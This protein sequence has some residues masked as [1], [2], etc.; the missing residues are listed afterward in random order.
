MTMKRNLAKYLAKREEK[1]ARHERRAARKAAK[2]Q[3]SVKEKNKA[4]SRRNSLSGLP[5]IGAVST[6]PADTALVR[7]GHHRHTSSSASGHL[8]LDAPLPVRD[9]FAQMPL[10]PPVA[11]ARGSTR[12]LLQPWSLADLLSA[13]VPL[14]LYPSLTDI[15]S[16]PSAEERVSAV[17]HLAL[18]NSH[19]AHDQAYRAYLDPS[20]AATEALLAREL[21]EASAKV[22]HADKIVNDLPWLPVTPS[23]FLSL[24]VSLVDLHKLTFLSRPRPVI[25]I[26]SVRSGRPQLVFESEF[27]P[28]Q[29]TEH[30]FA[31]MLLRLDELCYQQLERDILLRVTSIAAPSSSSLSPD[32]LT[33]GAA[34]RTLVGEVWTNLFKLQSCAPGS[35]FPVLRPRPPEKAHKGPKE[36]GTLV[37]QGV[38]LFVRSSA[39]L[40]AYP[41]HPNRCLP[42]TYP[43]IFERVTECQLCF[44]VQ[45]RSLAA[46]ADAKFAEAVA[47]RQRGA[48]A[49]SS[50]SS[51]SGKKA[52]HHPP[53]PR[54][55]PYLE[56]YRL[57]EEGVWSKKPVFTTEEV[58]AGSSLANAHAANPRG[59]TGRG[60]GDNPHATLTWRPVQMDLF[61]LC[62]GDVRRNVLVKVMTGATGSAGGALGSGPT[63]LASFQFQVAEV[64]ARRDAAV[65]VLDPRASASNGASAAAAVQSHHHHR[66][67]F[68][69]EGASPANHPAGSPTSPRGGGGGSQSGGGRI[70]SAVSPATLT[71]EPATSSHHAVMSEGSDKDRPAC[72]LFQRVH[73]YSSIKSLPALVSRAGIT[74]APDDQVAALAAKPEAKPLAKAISGLH[75]IMLEQEKRRA[76]ATGPGSA[77]SGFAAAVSEP[78]RSRSGSSSSSSLASSSVVAAAAVAGVTPASRRSSRAAAVADSST[79]TATATAG[80]AAQSVRSST[81]LGTPAVPSS[82]SRSR[83]PSLA[84]LSVDDDEEKK[85]GPQ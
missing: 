70:P 51:S 25:E 34:V 10:A 4:S 67:S 85:G 32:L 64:L 63:L 44:T 36:K 35:R 5:L 79:P 84:A 61:A 6:T 68:L 7:S 14:K 50:S 2:E 31:P 46:L 12:N 3:A 21:Q 59:K 38:S 27:A 71:G 58:W 60:G 8:L 29:C 30:H 52:A 76:R 37:V 40:L 81:P 49:S 28:A 26:Y 82:S 23:I 13:P 53:A 75:Q 43:A 48:S 1:R 9:E 69:S 65:V 62:F 20:G 41:D 22:S 16:L 77:R 73:V 15:L 54:V 42:L 39:G 45:C 72:I 66:A 78:S 57:E 19:A 56:F 47:L 18:T 55:C 83:R 24:T 17:Q 74:V 80:T 33:G 11:Y